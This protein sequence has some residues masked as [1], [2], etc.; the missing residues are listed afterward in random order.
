MVEV[1][2][3][4]RANEIPN[5]ILTRLLDFLRRKLS[6]QVT[7]N[8][9]DGKILNAEFRERVVAGKGKPE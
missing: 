6:G 7:L 9:H 8:V 3:E 2:N 5:S 1:N 4:D